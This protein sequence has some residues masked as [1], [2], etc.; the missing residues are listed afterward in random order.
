MPKNTRALLLRLKRDQPLNCGSRELSDETLASIRR[1]G[2]SAS[3]M[4]LCRNVIMAM[5]ASPV[6]ASQ[7]SVSG[8]LVLR[9][10]TARSQRQSL[11]VLTYLNNLKPVNTRVYFVDTT[12]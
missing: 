1:P 5:S 3:T 11:R 12:L 9:S 10:L 8:D 6:T 2:G 7:K 4:C